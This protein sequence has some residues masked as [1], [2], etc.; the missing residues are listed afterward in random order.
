MSI[1]LSNEMSEFIT[2][3]KKCTSK[4]QHKTINTFQINDKFFNSKHV[5]TYLCHLQYSGRDLIIIYNRIYSNN[6]SS[7]VDNK[8]QC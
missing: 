4:L 2:V 5:S 3:V 1:E 6:M 7:D 8:L